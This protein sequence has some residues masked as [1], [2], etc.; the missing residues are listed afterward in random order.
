MLSGMVHGLRRF[1]GLQPAEMVDLVQA[2]WCLVR[3]QYGIWTGRRSQLLPVPAS[4][5]AHEL[6]LTQLPILD[7]CQAA[8]RRAA[9][10]T[11]PF[12]HPALYKP[13]HFVTCCSQEDFGIATCVWV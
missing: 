7:R 1:F 5:A 4:T 13:W 9:A 10:L 3:V 2:Q 6:E 11:A 8:F 12:A